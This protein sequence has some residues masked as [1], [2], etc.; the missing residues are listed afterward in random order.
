MAHLP[1]ACAGAPERLWISKIADQRHRESL[2]ALGRPRAGTKKLRGSINITIRHKHTQE[3]LNAPTNSVYQGP[4]L[5]A[6][7]RPP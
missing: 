3:L 5:L 6:A 2:P 1:E 7:R 4:Q